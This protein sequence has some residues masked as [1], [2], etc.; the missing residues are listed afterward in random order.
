VLDAAPTVA[1]LAARIVLQPHGG[2][3][4]VCAAMAA[5]PPSA[6]VPGGHDVLGFL[7]CGA[8]LR[9]DAYLRVGGF[10]PRYGIGG[11]EELLALDLAAAGYT[12]GYLPEL[13][14]YHA[15]HPAPRGEERHTRQVR[16]ALWTTWLRR[17]PVAALHRTAAVLARSWRTGATWRGF[18]AAVAGLPWVLPERARI[19]P[20][21]EAWR[22]ALDRADAARAMSFGA[23][24]D[25]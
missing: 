18:A 4:P 1:L 23:G 5:G 9:R 8:V 19:D 15:P 21:L 25:G 6:V 13:V 12:C 22:T 24:A 3:D 10:H 2:E 17:H 14:A 11:E 7:A 16:N 20:A